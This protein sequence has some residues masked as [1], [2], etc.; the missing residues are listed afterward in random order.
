M[1]GGAGRRWP[2]YEPVEPGTRPPLAYPEYRSTRL[3]SPL[4]VPVDLPQ[5]LTEVTGPLLGADRVL[6]GDNDL[7]RRRDAEPIGQRII[8]HGRVMD[9]DGRAVPHTLVEVWQ[10]NAAGRYRHERDQWDAPLDPNF[11]GLGRTTTDS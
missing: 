10:A 9:S 8:V 5:R 11:D 3:R 7:T 2:H 6:P 1:K 4:R